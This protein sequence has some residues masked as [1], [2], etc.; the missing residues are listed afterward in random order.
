M[1]TPPHS[2]PCIS[3]ATVKIALDA[4]RA[5]ASSSLEHLL[6]VDEVLM[7]S[8]FPPS[9]NCRSY[10]LSHLLSA[11]ITEELD[12]RRQAFGSH[13]A[14]LS[15]S[16][17]VAKQAIRRDE[18]LSS[19]E[20]LGWNWLYYHYVRVDLDISR[21]R[22]CQ[23]ASID[24][25][26]LHRYQ[27]SAVRRLTACLMEREWHIRKEWHRRRLYTRLPTV[28]PSSFYGREDVLKQVSEMYGHSRLHQFQVFGEVGIGKTAFVQKAV[29]SLIDS[30]SIDELIWLDAPVSRHGIQHHLQQVLKDLGGIVS[31]RE[32]TQSHRVAFVFDGLD[33]WEEG[34][35]TLETLL[36]DLGAAIVFLTSLDP[37][38][39]TTQMG[40]IALSELSAPDA[41]HLIRGLLNAWHV[42]CFE[43]TSMDV[44]AIW[45]QVGGNPRLIMQAVFDFQSQQSQRSRNY[46]Q[47]ATSKQVRL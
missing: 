45:E 40:Y 14:A 47:K 15:N 21:D 33:S 25:R 23:L 29:R 22:F 46:P 5:Q 12:R 13:S 38:P 35:Q 44:Q 4:L 32:Y 9:A 24:L 39:L 10:A 3:E 1:F 8:A 28:T 11:V 19:P 42:P 27:Q 30:G 6:L 7:D 36:S 20:V 17:E 34:S 2:L 16:L 43:P 26:T 37:L 18:Q 31:M 41:N